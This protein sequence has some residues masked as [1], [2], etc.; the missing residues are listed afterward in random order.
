MAQDD[1]FGAEG[2][3]GEAGVFERLA[4]FDARGE[5]RNQRGVGAE[6]LGGELEAGAGARGGLV[7]EQRDAAL[8]QD[9]VADERVEIFERGGA[10]RAGG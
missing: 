10:D 7:E 5:A 8:G 3:Q 2:A 1:G 6:A 4:F 9:A